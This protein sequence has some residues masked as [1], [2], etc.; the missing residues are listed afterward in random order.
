M[1][2]AADLARVRQETRRRSWDDAPWL[3]K[4]AIV[5]SIGWHPNTAYFPAVEL[6]QAQRIE[7][8]AAATRLAETANL[9]A[10]CALKEIL[11]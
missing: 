5:Q 1:I 11:A 8:A 4:N 10:D 6:T 9:V 3:V 7:I 2:T